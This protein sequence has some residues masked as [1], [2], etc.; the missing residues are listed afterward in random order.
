[1]KMIINSGDLK[2]LGAL[3]GLGVLAFCSPANAAGNPPVKTA[4]I[5]AAPLKADNV[6]TSPQA[7]KSGG[8]A[9]ARD[10]SES[11]PPAW[12]PAYGYRRKEGAGGGFSPGMKN[13]ARDD[14]DEGRESE[15]GPP[16]WAPANGYRRKNGRGNFSSGGKR[17][18]PPSWAPAHGYRDKG[19]AGN[20]RPGRGGDDDRDEKDG[21]ENGPPPWAPAHGRRNK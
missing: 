4:P 9:E 13:K 2:S 1:M 20:A 18:G 10:E 15:A 19:G 7:L 8:A 5:K 12:A 17:G 3:A 6:I 21:A 14:A 11:G 16:S